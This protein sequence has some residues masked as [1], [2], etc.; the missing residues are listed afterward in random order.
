LKSELKK[1]LDNSCGSDFDNL[2]TDQVNVADRALQRQVT[3][4]FLENKKVY[5]S[6]PKD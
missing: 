6:I 1:L 5:T 4:W 3:R 2:P